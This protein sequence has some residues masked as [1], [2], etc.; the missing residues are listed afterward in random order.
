MVAFLPDDGVLFTGDVLFNQCTPIGW[1]GTFEQ[2][3]AALDRLAA[4][5]PAV[6]VPG[7]GPVCGVDELRE[8]RAYLDYVFREARVHYDAGLSTLEA[9]SR[10]ELGRFAGWEEPERLA[11]QV[12]RAYRQ[13][14]GL[15]WD[16][17]VDIVKVFGEVA[18]LAQAQ[19]QAKAAG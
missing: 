4:L 14:G 8:M 16:T 9:A 5:E 11:F 3:M 19:A 10:I 2:W 18:Q 15:P 17:P 12:N 1:E 6:V 7:H 13:F